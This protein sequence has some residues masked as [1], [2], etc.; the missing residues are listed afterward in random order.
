MSC[1]RALVARVYLVLFNSYLFLIHSLN[2]DLLLELLAL[3]RYHGIG[4]GDDWYN[5]DFVPEPLHEL[6]IEGFEPVAAGGDEVETAM[7]AG[8]GRGRLAR[9][10]GFRVQE[11]FVFRLDEVDDWLPTVTV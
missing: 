10:S 9:H 11:L 8:V 7:N 6:Y 4:L 2:T 3:L 1:G 5:V